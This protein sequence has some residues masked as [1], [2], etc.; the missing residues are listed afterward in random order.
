M[1]TARPESLSWPGDRLLLAWVRQTRGHQVRELAS[2]PLAQVAPLGGIGA[3][4][5]LMGS[6]RQTGAY[7]TACDHNQQW[8]RTMNAI[9]YKNT[10]QVSLS[11]CL[12][13][14]FTLTLL[15]EGSMG[16]GA[17]TLSVQSSAGLFHGA[18]SF[19]AIHPPS[20]SGLISA[21]LQRPPHQLHILTKG[22]GRHMEVSAAGL[23]KLCASGKKNV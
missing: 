15:S 13:R 17:M 1:R 23:F 2:S 7:Q 19:P 5:G 6:T 18:Q 12:L 10:V 14:L 11:P 3:D 8:Q 16:G 22:R 20:P 4:T 9:I 21:Q